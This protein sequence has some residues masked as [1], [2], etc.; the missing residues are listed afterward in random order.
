MLLTW[1][2]F[3]V[4]LLSAI[5]PGAKAKEHVCPKEK[6]QLA[7]PNCTSAIE[8]GEYEDHIWGVVRSGQRQNLWYCVGELN[9]TAYSSGLGVLKGRIETGISD[10]GIPYVKHLRENDELVYICK[11]EFKGNKPSQFFDMTVSSSVNCLTGEVGKDLYL[12]KSEEEIS[13]SGIEGVYWYAVYPNGTKQRIVYCNPT[14]LRRFERCPGSSCPEWFSRL[15]MDGIF[16]LV[17]KNL[18]KADRGLMFLRRIEPNV[19]ERTALTPKPLL[20]YVKIQHISGSTSGPSKTDHSTPT[21]SSTANSTAPKTGTPTSAAS[22]LL[23]LS[24]LIS[25]GLVNTLLPLL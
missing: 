12:K 18:T 20:D 25:L 24:V 9:C 15:E 8:S 19:R 21:E 17:L 5:L 13:P 4:L 11:V 14:G 1:K 3:A 6:V 10:L 2:L 16:T 7:I 23:P 22:G